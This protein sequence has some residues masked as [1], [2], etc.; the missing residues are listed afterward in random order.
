MSPTV[1]R[2]EG[3]RFYFFSRE[4]PRMHV[5]VHHQ[6]GEAKLWLEPR[7]ELAVDH[8]LGARRISRALQLAKEHEHEL[9]AAWKAHFRR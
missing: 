4:E 2:A 9:R 7:L 5:H 6:S 8:G 3:F 1:L